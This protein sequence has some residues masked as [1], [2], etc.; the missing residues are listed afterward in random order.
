MMVMVMVV[1]STA[2]ASLV[3]IGAGTTICFVMNMNEITF[4]HVQ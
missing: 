1:I 2:L 4:T 3:K